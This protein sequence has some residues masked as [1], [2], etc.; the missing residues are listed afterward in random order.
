MVDEHTPVFFPVV[1]VPQILE[2]HGIDEK[3]QYAPSS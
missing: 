1:K 3:L 2:V